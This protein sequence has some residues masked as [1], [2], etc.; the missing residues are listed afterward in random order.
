M[1]VDAATGGAA[2]GGWDGDV[3][4][5]VDGLEE[6][7]EDCGGD[8]TDDGSLTAG[9]HRRHEAAVEAEARVADGVDAAVDAVELATCDSIADGPRSQASAFDLRSRSYT[10][11]AIGDSGD[12]SVGRVEFLTHV[13]T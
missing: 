13:G 11:L 1:E 6:L 10:M 3:D 5:A 2:R 7:P 8:V 4:G 9:E 12:L